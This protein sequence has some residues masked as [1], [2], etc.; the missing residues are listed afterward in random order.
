MHIE[1]GK[2]PVRFILKTRRLMFFWHVLNKDK[3]D[4]LYTFLSARQLFSSRT[5]W[6]QQVRKDKSKIKLE[7]S[8][9]EIEN[10]S[11]EMFK[12]IIRQ[13]I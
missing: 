12:K 1:C 7:L 5:D 10:M 6:I 8:D 4:I 11:K 2:L 9:D 13:T 3:H